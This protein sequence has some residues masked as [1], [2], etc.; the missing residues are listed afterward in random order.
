MKARS[1]AEDT[2][3]ERHE[4]LIGS[5]VMIGMVVYADQDET[6]IW[7]DVIGMVVYVDRDGESA[8]GSSE[9]KAM[10]T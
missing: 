8:G 5:D 2:E 3:I 10:Q 4:T 1:I 7:T 6:L 9:G